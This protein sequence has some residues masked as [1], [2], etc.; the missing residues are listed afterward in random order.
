MLESYTT[1][2]V[3]RRGDRAGAARG[4]GDRHHL[5]QRRPPREDRGHARR[6][7]RR[8]GGLRPRARRGSRTSTGPTAGRSRR[9]PS[10]TPCSRTRSSSCR[11]CG[12]RARRRSEGR[13]L[14][15]PE[16]LCYPRPLQATCRSWWAAGASGAP[17]GSWPATPTPATSSA[18]ST[19]RPPQGS[20]CCAATATTVG[21]DP[22][23]VEV[24]QL[25]TTLVGRD[26][27]EVD[28]AGRAAPAPAGER[29]ALRRPG[30]RR[31][32]RRPGGPLPGPGR[33]GRRTSPW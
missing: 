8:A 29:R 5:P 23:T 31:H 30:Q 9:A 7:V 22:P 28:D 19:G 14:D 11:C 32:R 24:T 1:L 16:A 18:T 20:R 6:A 10:A 25:S 4:D 2:G 12:A 27:A 3:P 17:C 26:A 33:R 15:V 21:R 13:V